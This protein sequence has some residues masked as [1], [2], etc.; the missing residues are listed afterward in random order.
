MTSL[1]QLNHVRRQYMEVRDTLLTLKGRYKTRKQEKVFLQQQIAA[2]QKVVRKQC[3]QLKEGR[4]EILS[5]E[6]EIERL[7]SIL[8]YYREKEDGEER[9][10]REWMEVMESNEVIEDSGIGSSQSRV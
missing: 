8:S 5:G 3:I 7:S 9:L 1:V 10:E 6:T 4:A 2:F